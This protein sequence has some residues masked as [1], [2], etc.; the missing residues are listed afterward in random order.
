MFTLAHLS[1]PHLA[2]LPAPRIADLASKRVLGW[3]QLAGPADAAAACNGARLP[4][5]VQ[6]A[7][8]IDCHAPGNDRRRRTRRGNPVGMVAA[9]VQVLEVELP[10]MLP[11]IGGRE[12]RERLRC[13][14]RPLIQLRQNWLSNGC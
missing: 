12:L 14:L 7:G 3:L 10:M 9:R 6:T 8:R 5:D 2:P 11:L 13:E 4:D 1:D